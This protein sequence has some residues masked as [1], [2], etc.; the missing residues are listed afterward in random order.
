MHRETSFIV[1]VKRLTDESG[2]KPVLRAACRS[3]LPPLT[4]VA[5]HEQNGAPSTLSRK[6]FHV[7]I[8]PP[9]LA[10]IW[11]APPAAAAITT[12]LAHQCKRQ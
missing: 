8:S 3:E 10:A 7:K 9:S 5:E 12:E 11:W 2:K 1:D 4:S 6:T